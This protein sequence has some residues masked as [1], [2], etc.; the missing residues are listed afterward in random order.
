MFQNLEDRYQAGQKEVQEYARKKQRKSYRSL[1]SRVFITAA[2]KIRDYT[3][4][5]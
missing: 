4:V 1:L 3:I 5:F 2:Q